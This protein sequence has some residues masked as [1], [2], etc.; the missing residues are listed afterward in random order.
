MNSF[1]PFGSAE[2]C[3]S[4][5]LLSQPMKEKKNL[6]GMVYCKNRKNQET[7]EKHTNVNS[8]GKKIYKIM[9]TAVKQ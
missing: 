4:G 9:S 8:S 5:K 2:N 7:D 3:N 6:L 1:F